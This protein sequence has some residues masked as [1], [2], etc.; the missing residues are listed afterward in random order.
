MAIDS[1]AYSPKEFRLA[2]K[3]EST[4]G[5]KVVSSMQ[6]INVDSV[7]LPSLN[8]TQVFDMRARAGR[9]A[10]L[11]DVF[12]DGSLVDKEISFSGTADDTVL[13][14]LLKNITNSAIRAASSNNY[15]AAYVIPD[16]FTPTELKIEQG[17]LTADADLF[18]VA[19][20][21]PEAAM[22]IVFPSCRL[23]SLTISGD[24]G[25]ENGRIKISGSFKTK[26]NAFLNQNVT[27][28]TSYGSTFYS[29]Q[30]FGASKII[31]GASDCILQSFSLNIENPAEYIG[32]VSV[33]A[34]LGSGGAT[35]NQEPQV[36]AIGIP[37]VSA[38]LEA[39]IKYDSNTTGLDNSYRSGS[40]VTIH[41]SNNANWH[42]ATTFGIY[43]KKSIITSLSHNEGAAMMLDISS[44]LV[45]DASLS[46][47]DD[48]LFEI[49][50]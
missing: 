29:M 21:S 27:G 16:S 11:S 47:P 19:V 46:A 37:E 26:F 2:F 40:G 10:K 28:S 12:T 33:S 42:A 25:T 43:A 6:E 8:P 9:T 7:E 13:P 3:S 23:T 50:A 5:T 32:N 44:K 18:T 49:I 17:S 36:I 41:L 20:L 14:L 38:N 1:A 30:T 31:G 22:D 45:A 48:S 4:V 39:T 24:M 35:D 15:P 34:D